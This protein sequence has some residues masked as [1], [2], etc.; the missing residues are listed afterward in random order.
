MRPSSIRLRHARHEGPGFLWPG[1]GSGTHMNKLIRREAGEWTGNVKGD[2]LAGIVSAFAVIPEVIGF[3]IVAGVDPILGLYTSVVFLIV[4][5]LLGGHPAMVSAGAGSMAVVVITLIANHGLEYLFAAVLLAGVLQIALSLCR[6]GSLLTRM[7]PAIMSGFVDAL[8]LIIFKAQVASFIQNMGTTPLVIAETVAFVV[9]GLVITFWFNRRS[10]ALPSSLV[11]IIVVT[12]LSLIL[13]AAQGG[14]NGAT[15]IADLGDLTAT[16]PALGL[17][18]VPLSLETLG[19]IA[20]YSVSL[21]F[22]GLLETMMT[23]KV[24]DEMTGAHG[25][26]NREC[27]AQGIANIACGV[28]GAMPGCAMIGQAI[29]CVSSGG[30]GRLSTFVSGALLLCLL[31]FGSAVLGAVPLAA[32]I[33]VMVF[34]SYSTFNRPQLKRVFTDHSRPALCEYAI[35]LLIVVVVLATNNL[36]LGIAAGLALHFC[37]KPLNREA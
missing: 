14:S 37:L 1:H 16:L 4:L 17:P 19:I 22:V 24:V 2:V 32:L 34:V 15:M 11:A 36:A 3:T 26:S 12:V 8:A 21:A 30:R 7:P 13:A 10:G 33:A 20:P 35:T 9:V 27:A 25:S 5:S 18:Q 23:A 29:A 6:I 31:V 28:I